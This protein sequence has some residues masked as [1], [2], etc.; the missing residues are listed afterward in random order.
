M[1]YGG[2]EM[3]GHPDKSEEHAV[4]EVIEDKTEDDKKSPGTHKSSR[5]AK[6]PVE[7]H[8][9][10]QPAPLQQQKKPEQQNLNFYDQDKT[11]DAL[12]EI[13]NDDANDSDEIIFTQKD[14]HK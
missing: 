10:E 14:S 3:A 7:A 2:E 5:S 1:Y 8:V 11:E 4:K 12:E 13:P 9:E 6:A